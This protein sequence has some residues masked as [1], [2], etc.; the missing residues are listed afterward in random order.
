MK[1]VSLY[2]FLVSY[3]VVLLHNFIPHD[4]NDGLGI[5]IHKYCD[6]FSNT[7]HHAD[8]AE[9]KNNTDHPE[10][11]NHKDCEAQKVN[12]VIPDY[13]LNYHLSFCEQ[14]Q[15]DHD[16]S[17]SSLL[18]GHYLPITNQSFF[19]EQVTHG[20]PHTQGGFLTTQSLRGPPLS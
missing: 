19:T 6:I 9:E 2:I 13:G 1:Q 7:H 11:Q 10:N 18:S 12:F 4:H 5:H 16:N 8:G 3:L 15:S 20:P 14:S 17:I